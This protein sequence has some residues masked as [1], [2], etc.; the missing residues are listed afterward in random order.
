MF[1]HHVMTVYCA[2]DE[3]DGPE[4]ILDEEVQKQLHEMADYGS[5][6][7]EEVAAPDGPAGTVVNLL[8]GS[9]PLWQSFHVGMPILCL[10]MQLCVCIQCFEWQNTAAALHLHGCETLPYHC[11]TGYCRGARI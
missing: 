11:C 6:N 7:E 1:V 9:T 2:Q 5:G 3:K 8:A 10:R 4:D